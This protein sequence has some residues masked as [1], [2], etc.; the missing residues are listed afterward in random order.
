MNSLHT[1]KSSLAPAWRSSFLHDYATN[2]VLGG[3]LVICFA[4]NP[5]RGMTPDWENPQVIGRNKEPARWTALP[6]ADADQARQGTR[7]A[8]PYYQSLNGQWTFHWTKRP[9]DRPKHFHQKDFDDRDWDT[10]AVPSNWQMHGYGTPIYSNIT[11]PFPKN[12]P[13]IAHD[14]N[15]VGSYRTTFTLPATWKGR[16]VILHFAGVESA[17]YVWINGHRVG[18]SQGSRTPAEFDITDYVTAASNLLAVE[19]YRWCDG[20][21]LEDQDFWRLSGI[22]RDVFLYSTTQVHVRDVWVR[23]AAAETLAEGPVHE[24]VLVNAVTH[25][26]LVGL[27]PV[28]VAT[29]LGID[30]GLPRIAARQPSGLAEVGLERAH[31]DRHRELVGEVIRD[32]AEDRF[33]LVL[34]RIIG[35]T[36]PLVR[37]RRRACPGDVPRR[38]LPRSA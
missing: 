8:S 28:G 16:R 2:R 36:P 25:I 10:I 18:Y 15:P 11:Y 6:Y 24:P 32:L 23:A 5:L 7:E 13:F 17:C 1:I 3:L 19:V 9:A 4:C 29:V 37:Q 30:L 38:C 33:F 14:N 31:A 34:T 12:P 26:N 20:S 21:Y 27:I 35:A 22:F